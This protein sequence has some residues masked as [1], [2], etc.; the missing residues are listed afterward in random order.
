MLE[1][2]P[3]SEQDAA[4]AFEMFIDGSQCHCTLKGL[5][6]VVFTQRLAMRRACTRCRRVTQAMEGIPGQR[7]SQADE[8]RRDA[9]KILKEKSFRA[10][11]TCVNFLRLSDSRCRKSAQHAQETVAARFRRP[12]PE[13]V[14]KDAPDL[15]PSMSHDLLA[16]PQDSSSNNW[17]M[18]SPDEILPCVQRTLKTAR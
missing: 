8:I 7:L 15:S 9:E 3:A 16:I 2:R 17:E 10:I 4:F 13:W 11:E 18:D 12:V 14:D 6:S 5:P 1:F